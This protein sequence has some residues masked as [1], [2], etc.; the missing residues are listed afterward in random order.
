MSYIA[1][2]W[3]SKRGF[4]LPMLGEYGVGMVFLPKEHASTNGM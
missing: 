4:T 1:N 3:L 2:K